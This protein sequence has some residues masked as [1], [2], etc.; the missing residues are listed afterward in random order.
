[1]QPRQRAARTIGVGLL[2]VAIVFVA[3]KLLLPVTLGTFGFVAATLPLLAVLAWRAWPELARALLGFAAL[4]R[5]PVL[6]ITVVAVAN[7]WGTHYE[8]L[9]PGSPPMGD[10]ARTLVLCTAQAC[11]W[12][13]LTL[14]VGGLAGV[15]AARRRH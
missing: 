4:Q 9:A 5:L 15:L 3:A 11:L 6:A 8:R 2:G 7:D 12:V 14:L 1:M 10:G 13:P